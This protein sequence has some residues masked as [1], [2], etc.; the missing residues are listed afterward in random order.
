[1]LKKITARANLA[2]PALRALQDAA[3]QLAD[4]DWEYCH[5]REEDRRLDFEAGEY[6]R[7][8]AASDEWR[9]K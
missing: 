7:E 3:S 4:L 1:M 5:D 2:M 6:G 9:E 8:L